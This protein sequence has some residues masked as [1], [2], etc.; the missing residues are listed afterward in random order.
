MESYAYLYL[1]LSY[2]NP[3]QLIPNRKLSSQAYRWLL[4]LGTMLLI[5]SITHAAQA[6]LAI[7]DFGQEVTQIQNRL[8]ELGYL[9][10]NATG[11]FGEETQNA[12]IQFQRDNRLVQDGIVGPNTVVALIATNQNTASPPLN[13]T[14][15]SDRQLIGLGLGDSG[16][17]VTNLQNRLRNLGFF[18]NNSTGYFGPITRNAVIRFQQ[19]NSIAATGLVTEDT[20]A[21]LN[22][23]TGSLAGNVSL[24]PGSF[25]PIVG[26][27][28]RELQRLGFFPGQITNF[29]DEV[30]VQAVRNFQMV[31]GLT[32]TGFIG[33][34]TQ[35]LLASQQ[36]L[37]NSGITS[38]P[39]NVS[40]NQSNPSSILLL[41]SR[42]ADV[43]ALQQ[44]LKQLGYYTGM[45]DGVFDES[46]RV[47]V[48][49]F[50]RDNGITQTG[51]VGPTTQFH[52]ARATTQRPIIPVVPAGPASVVRPVVTNPNTYITIGNAGEDVR[53]IQ[54]RLR[55]L[56]FYNGPINGFF[57]GQTQN[58][59]IQFQ[60]AYNITNTG[61]VGP[62]TETY[63]FNVTRRSFGHINNHNPVSISSSDTSPGL[64]RQTFHK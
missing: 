25:G 16:P 21:I 53:R 58:A 63:L 43:I 48:V 38:N 32:P 36:M 40:M 42:G 33:P 12:V 44:R 47:A 4:S 1:A 52:L 31:N 24:G 3:Q 37:G 39:T 27:V 18:N 35:S 50:Q 51:Q 19:A 23:G 64:Q 26:L 45:I 62:T 54:R 57:D 8:R 56:G 29:Y 49:R 7:G 11:Y 60:Q 30:T 20:L 17:G 14:P 46:T 41:G 13:T 6:V 61:I 59:V 10:A 34:T 9:S 28:Q 5:L 22:R 15:V 2:Q 55:E